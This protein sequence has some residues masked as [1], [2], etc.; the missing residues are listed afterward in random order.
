MSGAG[1]EGEAE[2]DD[3]GPD[4]IIILDN[5]FIVEEGSPEELLENEG[6]FY[7]MVN[8][9]NKSINWKIN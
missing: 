7:K 6:I 9:Q 1:D 2:P 5:G 4:K 3:N 8:I